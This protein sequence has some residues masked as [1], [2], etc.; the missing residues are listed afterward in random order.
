MVK[1]ETSRKVRSRKIFLILTKY[2]PH[3][4]GLMY[5]IYTIGEF[6]E[7]DMLP[8]GYMFTLTVLPWIYFYSASIALEFCYVHRLPLYYILADE[9]LLTVDYY[10]KIP[11]NV[12]HLFLLHKILIGILI[13]GYTYYYLKELK[14]R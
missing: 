7:Y 12:Y 4:I 14:N 3:I 11:L 8:L 9:L 1:E 5:I 2:I 6:F 10:F 13:F